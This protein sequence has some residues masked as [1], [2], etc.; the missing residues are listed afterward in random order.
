HLYY[1]RRIDDVS[2]A[3]QYVLTD[4]GFSPNSFENRSHR[5][6]SPDILPQEYAATFSGDYRVS[7]LDLITSEGIMG[8]DLRYLRHEIRE[9]K[10]ALPG[11]PAAFAGEE[12]VQTLSL[13]LHDAATGLEVELLYGVFEASD[14]LTRAAVFRNAGDSQI[15]LKR[16]L[17][18][19]LDIPFGT[20]ELLHFHGRHCMERTAERVPLMHGIQTVSSSRGASSHH[21]NP[22]VVLLEERAN[23]EQGT[24]LGIMPVYSGNHRTDVEVDQAGSL[25][26]VSG[27]NHEAFSWQL[28]P[29]ETF[30]APEVILCYTG[31]GLESLSHHY[32]DFLEQHVIRSL[33]R[34][35]KRPLILNSWEG[36]N[37]DF[38][39][40]KVIAFA[41]EA[42]QLGIEL[43][44]LDDGWFGIR[45]DDNTG[46]G[47]WYANESKLPGG[48]GPI[49]DA[50]HGL[51]M[52][53]GLWFEPEMVNEDSELYRAHPQWALT[54]PGRPPTMSRNQLALDM[55]RKDV[56]DHL[57]RVMAD[58]IQEN[59]I[60]YIKWDLN[61]NLGDLYSHALSPHR[62]GETAH[63]YMLGVYDLMERLT[64]DF[65]E[66]LFEG[67]A[68]GGGRFDAGMLYYMPQIW[69]SD[70]T[71]AIERLSIQQGTSV[72]YPLSTV[73]AHL[74]A[75][76][77]Q[78]TG[79]NT[80]YFTRAAVAMH[81]TF[82]YELDP[83]H[84]TEAEKQEIREEIAWYH[85]LYPLLHE[86]RLHRLT[87]LEMREDFTA[88]EVARRD[89]SEALVT[90]VVTRTRA[91]DHGYHV[92]LRGLAPKARYRIAQA[93]FEGG[94][95]PREDYLGRQELDAL[96]F[97]GES[98]MY[99][100]FTL[101]PL[102]GDYPA[103]QLLFE[104]I[105]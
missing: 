63:R 81:G 88:W 54:V 30:F 44:V 12:K 58:L 86:G 67:C 21:H 36:M 42:A 93:E 23:E 19:C 22:F 82:G 84:F 57:Y 6:V 61:R 80:S 89:G 50:I 4:C 99:A 8:A 100:G 31:D 18:L 1:G 5:D 17:S 69:C 46:L 65:P 78:Q 41:E 14:M 76:P 77:N 62:Q 40:A 95:L 68:G 90:F 75:C 74:S 3:S 32:H 73:G 47:D 91:N 26:V 79:R 9:G 13:T 66:V 28:L 55:G 35:R 85:Q 15:T 59:H 72:G 87:S 56:V 97:T 101:P 11:L 16:A 48:L 33:W 2:L 10:Y 43:V 34:D 37:F 83:S 96:I 64:R 24:C 38:D 52:Q 92:R 94:R 49:S 71:D 105:P 51:G 98:L 70:D 53:F 104:R 39:T 102:K 27:I 103:A 7:A 29:G 45:N 60:D 25:R 20:W